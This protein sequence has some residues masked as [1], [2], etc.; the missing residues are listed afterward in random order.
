MPAIKFT[1]ISDK[2]GIFNVDASS[3]PDD[4]LNGYIPRDQYLQ[5][6]LREQR[7][8]ST[9]VSSICE[10]INWRSIRLDPP[11]ETSVTSVLAPDF[12]QA[13]IVLDNE[14]YSQY[15]IAPATPPP[16]SYY[17]VI[18]SFSK[19][20]FSNCPNCNNQKSIFNAQYCT[21]CGYG[22]L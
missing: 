14:Q 19:A 4:Q 10:P 15:A 22:Y 2:Y 21:Q 7:V 9:T 13:T 5:F 18:D 8:A 16:P 17:K 6:G 11:A 20:T 12:E 1:I 3:Y